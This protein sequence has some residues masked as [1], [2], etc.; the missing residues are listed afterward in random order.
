MVMVVVITCL[1]NHYKLSARSFINR[2]SQGRRRDENLSSVSNSPLSM[3]ALLSRWQ[4]ACEMLKLEGIQFDC[5]CQSSEVHLL[6]RTLW[7]DTFQAATSFTWLDSYS[8][9]CRSFRLAVRA[10]SSWE[11]N[12]HGCE[13]GRF[14]W[15]QAQQPFYA[16]QPPDM[17]L[18]MHTLSGPGLKGGTTA[19]TAG[20]RIPPLIW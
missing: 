1:L 4:E 5:T 11:Q 8:I 9:L 2:H 6:F 14:A 13:V 12:H 16:L 19:E 3:Y 20:T 17:Q 18:W 7:T 15:G 10:W